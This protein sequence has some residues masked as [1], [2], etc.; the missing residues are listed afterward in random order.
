VWTGFDWFKIGF[1]G[2]GGGSCECGTDLWFYK[3]RKIFRL[4]KRMSAFKEELCPME[5]EMK[6]SYITFTHMREFKVMALQGK[7]Q[8]R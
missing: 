3:G 8:T 5:L 1:G 4:T 7:C 2:G 6:G